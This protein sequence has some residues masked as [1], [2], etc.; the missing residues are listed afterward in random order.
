MV[1]TNLVPISLSTS[2]VLQ[3]LLKV[4]RNIKPTDNQKEDD[5][6]LVMFQLL[7]QWL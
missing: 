6:P 7:E 5:I 3:F 4:S 2:F 1:A